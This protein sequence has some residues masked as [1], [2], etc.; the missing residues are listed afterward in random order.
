MYIVKRI[1]EDLDFGCEERE[2]G[3]PVMAVV[4]LIDSFGEEMRVKAEDAMLYERDINEGDKVYFDK[5]K[6]EKA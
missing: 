5:D 2:E 3:A 1:E 4:T 6:L